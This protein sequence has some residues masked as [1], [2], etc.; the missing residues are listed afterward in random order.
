M[1]IWRCRINKYCSGSDVIQSA[2]LEIQ[3]QVSTAEYKLCYAECRSGDAEASKYCRVSDVIQSGGAGAGKYCR[4]SDVIQS[5][6][7][8][9]QV[10]SAE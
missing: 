4:V 5:L 7:V 10:S 1:Q 9:E 3:E 6:E 2:E 8:Q